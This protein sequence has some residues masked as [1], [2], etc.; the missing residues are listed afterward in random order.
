MRSAVSVG[1]AAG[2][3]TGTRGT[4]KARVDHSELD[5]LRLTWFERSPLR[6]LP[7][8]GMTVVD[9]EVTTVGVTC[10]SLRKPRVPVSRRGAETAERWTRA[11]DAS[12]SE[13]RDGYAALRAGVAARA[14]MAS[15]AAAL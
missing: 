10:M 4:S 6:R 8:V 2:R 7:L 5:G 11:F 9:F 15:K 3:L 12:G 14:D 13:G 1:F